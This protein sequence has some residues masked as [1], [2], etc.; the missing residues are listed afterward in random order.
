MI[1]AAFARPANQQDVVIVLLGW[2]AFELKTAN[3]RAAGE[4]HPYLWACLPLIAVAVGIFWA[5]RS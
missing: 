3:L 1:L 2:I 5:T 4:K